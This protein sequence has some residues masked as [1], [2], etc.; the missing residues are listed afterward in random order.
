M[1]DNDCTLESDVSQYYDKFELYDI[2]YIYIGC[3]S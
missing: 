3:S 2:L 1:F